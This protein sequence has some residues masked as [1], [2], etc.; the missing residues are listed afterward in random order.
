MF[1]NLFSFFSSEMPKF[2]LQVERGWSMRRVGR[3]LRP[4]Y[5]TKRELMDDQFDCHMCSSHCI[6][7]RICCNGVDECRLRA[8]IN[9][10]IIF[11]CGTQTQYVKRNQFCQNFH[12]AK[13]ETKTFGWR[14]NVTVMENTYAGKVAIFHNSGETHIDWP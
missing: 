14:S 1:F 13:S 4:R 12:S 5:L 9:G 11:W 2:G 7:R 8:M 6:R 10:T 3:K